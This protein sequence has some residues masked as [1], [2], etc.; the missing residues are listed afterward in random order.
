MTDTSIIMVERI[1]DLG[2]IIRI[3]GSDT[4][5]G[6]R[7]VVSGDFRPM[8]EALNALDVQVGS[9]VG[10]IWYEDGPALADVWDVVELNNEG[11][12]Q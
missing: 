9:E 12:K 6:E 7:V 11:E 10:I 5:D 2:S 4:T 1:T 3:I 8:R